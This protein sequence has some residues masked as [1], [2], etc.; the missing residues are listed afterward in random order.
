MAEDCFHMSSKELVQKELLDYG[1]FGYVFLCK[2]QKHGLVVM[3]KVYTGPP[4]NMS[5][6]QCLLEEGVLMNRLNHK[7]IV[8]LLG[9][10]LEDGDYSLVMEYIPKGNLLVMLNKVRVPISIQG[11]II[12]EIIEGMK[13]L[14]EKGIIHKDLKPE[15]I[16][17]DRDN[18]IKIADLGLAT[19]Q[20]WS[21]LTKEESRRQSCLGR[22][23]VPNA[24]GTLSYI[25]PEHLE[26]INT[27]STEKSDVYSFAIVIWV[28]LAHKEPYENAHNEEHLCRCVQKGDRPDQ[29]SI[30]SDTPKE[31]I[32]LMEHCWQSN[33]K[34][35]PTFA[36]CYIKFRPF[37]E[38][39]L[40]KLVEQ[41]LHILDEYEG[42]EEFVEKMISL[43]I[44]PK[45]LP[46]DNPSSLRC[47]EEMPIEASEEDLHL[48]LLNDS[49]QVDAA[50]DNNL[51]KKLGEE[52]GYHM[53]GQ[54][55]DNMRGASADSQFP[56]SSVHSWGPN[57]AKPVIDNFLRHSY[58][59]ESTPR[60][61]HQPSPV[62]LP[63]PLPCFYLGPSQSAYPVP[64]SQLPDISRVIPISPHP[65]YQDTGSLIIHN[66]SGV[67]IGDNNTLSIGSQSFTS[68]SVPSSK[69]SPELPQTIEHFPVEEEHLELLRDNLGREWKHCARK[70]GL[71]Q[72]EID[73]IDH[74]Y[75][76][77][78]L[79][80]KVYQMLEKWKMKEGYQGTTM[81]K[82]YRALI[83]SVKGDLISRLVELC[84]GIPS[85]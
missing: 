74:D 59:H 17:I 79:K 23:S 53:H 58:D 38:D 76:R 81:G 84:N 25:A 49:I 8:K 41:E 6:K 57:D 35:R 40:E 2:H 39:K 63:Q 21:K 75:E 15:N 20:N 71:T 14:S 60:G 32:K 7:R 52:L 70:L 24:A 67:Q 31:I 11:R 61:H 80:E 66:A 47:V 83:D 13:Y 45:S 12:L 46:A 26:S 82:L 68:A 18:H 3:K 55:I 54:R 33:P 62:S 44:D 72:V 22:K 36:E 9:V 78:G 27:K 10:I 64:E 43:T 5:S 19:C 37:Y 16:L 50:P 65:P 56:K 73:A 48:H 85:Q 69:I 77:D 42:P 30:P 34:Q 28:I 29:E 4:R 51:Q 1:G